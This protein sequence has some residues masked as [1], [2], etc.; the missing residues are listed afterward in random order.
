MTR[1]QIFGGCTS[2]ILVLAAC[3]AVPARA[4]EGEFGIQFGALS[5]DDEISGKS[6]EIEPVLGLRSGYRF[7]HHWGW[8][9]DLWFAKLNAAE[10]VPPI[11]DDAPT[12]AVRTGLEALLGPEEA[13]HRLFLNFGGGVITFDLQN[14][15][16]R[17]FASIGFG[18]RLTIGEQKYLRWELR[19]DRTLGDDG[20]RGKDL[21]NPQLLLGLTWGIGGRMLDDDGDGVAN[22][23]DRCLDTPPGA[24]I[25]E[26]GCPIDSDHDGVA[27]GLDR[28]SDTESG[29]A[30]D[31]DGCPLDSDGDGVADTLDSCA[32]TARGAKV[33]HSG[34]PVD[35][36]GDGVPDGV[37]RCAGTPKDVSV[38]AGGCPLDG[39]GDGVADYQDRCPNTV[40]GELV[41]A[42][43]CPRD[44]DR[45]GVSDSKDEC[46]D[47]P[48]NALVYGNGC[49]KAFF[50]GGRTTL[51]LEGVTFDFDSDALTPNSRTILDIVAVSLQAS[52]KIR[53]EI[54]GHTDSEGG[55]AYNEQLSLRRAQ[56]VRDHLINKGI[57]P[58]RLEVRG[59]GASEP[60]S[61]NDTP[62]GRALNRRVEL[63]KLE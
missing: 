10:G 42:A 11:V 30:V 57:D 5:P 29:W 6:N 53:V 49:P 61:D 46:A 58:G 28:C 41:D 50:D 25:D 31:A 47:T 36:D 48:P 19:G 4:G 23:R 18:Q 14:D 2:L 51:I 21:T 32:G 45:D 17:A 8:M 20:F 52:S 15:V 34:C 44:S 9:V 26:R 33:D 60:K 55:E 1:R 13:K 3:M 39:D 37:D 27:D 40:S 35:G 7:S 16:D 54:G 43:G 59:Y 22:R 63:K 24:S 62:E 38:D 12:V 56:A